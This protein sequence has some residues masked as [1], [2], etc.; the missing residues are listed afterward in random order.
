[1]QIGDKRETRQQYRIA[2]SKVRQKIRINIE[3]VQ[4]KRPILNANNNKRKT[5][6]RL[7]SIDCTFQSILEKKNR[8]ILFFISYFA[9]S[10]S[11]FFY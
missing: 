5:Q 7:S 8:S 3:C 10:V 1:M 4:H 9:F 6:R 2:V 11:L